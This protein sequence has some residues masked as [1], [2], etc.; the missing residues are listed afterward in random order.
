M[1]CR[2]RSTYLLFLVNV[3]IQ[4]L[5]GSREQAA[6]QAAAQQCPSAHRQQRKTQTGHTDAALRDTRG[7]HKPVRRSCTHSPVQKKDAGGHC[8][9]CRGILFLGGTLDGGSGLVASDGKQ[10]RNQGHEGLCHGKTEVGRETLATSSGILPMF[11]HTPSGWPVNTPFPDEGLEMHGNKNGHAPH[12][13]RHH[14]PACNACDVP[15]PVVSGPDWGRLRRQQYWRRTGPPQ[16]AST[17]SW[18][19]PAWTDGSAVHVAGGR[20]HHR[21]T[22]LHWWT[23]GLTA[24]QPENGRRTGAKPIGPH[25]MWVM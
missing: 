12:A 24:A 21:L 1:T 13:C 9:C 14:M 22:H 5:H 6:E 15:P 18:H 20:T 19:C 17:A 8:G 2:R 16:T 3:L 25:K 11:P 4:Q 10:P 7:V 23:A